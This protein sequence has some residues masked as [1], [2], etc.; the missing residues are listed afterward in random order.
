MSKIKSLPIERTTDLDH[1]RNPNSLLSKK[2]NRLYHDTIDVG[3]QTKVER[4]G[5]GCNKFTR[6]EKIKYETK[7][8]KKTC[9]LKATKNTIL[10]ESKQATLR[11]VPS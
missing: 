4:N 10:E 6:N 7:L 9:M 3:K 2:N 1:F 8:V 5:N 11:N